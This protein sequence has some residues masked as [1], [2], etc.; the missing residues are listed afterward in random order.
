MAL[1]RTLL[2]ILAAG[3]LRAGSLEG[4]VAPFRQA[5]VSAQVSSYLVEIKVKE[6]DEVKAGQVLA[7]LFGKLEELEVQRA[8][9]LLERKEFE[10]KG[11]TSLFRDRVIPE[12]QARESRIELELARLR[13]EG[14]QEQLRL[15]TI[16][17]PI[18]GVVQARLRETGEAVGTAQPLFR[19]VDLSKAYVLFTV[20]P[21]QLTKVAPGQKV[22]LKLPQVDGGSILSGEVVFVDPRADS[23]GNF[24][25][26]V[27]VAEPGNHVRAGLKALVELPS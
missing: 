23:D 22:S 15:R 20:K 21:E 4:R 26:K 27:L 14:A 1:R 8:K 7:Q 16:V 6:G 25:V 18:D 5:E 13:L 2:L 9:A 17:A 10:A 12:S 3:T 11:A 19:I 24:R